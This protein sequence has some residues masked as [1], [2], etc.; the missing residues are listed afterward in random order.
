MRGVGEEKERGGKHLKHWQR[1]SGD[2]CKGGPGLYCPE[3][4]GGNPFRNA[5]P[6]GDRETEGVG[7]QGMRGG[8]PS[9]NEGV[10]G[11]NPKDRWEHVMVRN[12][13]DVPGM[14]DLIYHEL[15]LKGLCGLH[16][17]NNL[18]QG[19]EW[20]EKTCRSSGQRSKIFRRRDTAI[21]TAGSPVV[22]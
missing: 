3:K 11:G 2:G 7:V 1:K 12:I 5:A 9:P 22:F 21:W 13:A 14:R 4:E 6:Q 20:Y 15:Q 8:G 18:M 19:P 16:A 10:E 17:L